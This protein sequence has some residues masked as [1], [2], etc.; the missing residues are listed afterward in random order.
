MSEGISS[1][2]AQ[3]QDLIATLH[4]FEPLLP[5]VGATADALAEA[6]LG[7]RKVLTAGNGGSA[8]DAL[9][10]AEELTGRFDRDRRALPA[11]SLCADAVTLTCIAN[12]F[13]FEAVFAR[14][15]ES[16]GQAGDVLVIFSTS[17]NSANLVTALHAARLH[18]IRTIAVLGKGGGLSRGLADHEIVVPSNVTARIQEVHTLILHLWLARI[19]AAVLSSPSHDRPELS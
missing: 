5:A 18:R 14:Q 11:L 2:A 3:L 1:S 7:G 10:F 15:I 8:A 12:D 19:E 13:G 9:H 6:L 16:L 17:G 4:S